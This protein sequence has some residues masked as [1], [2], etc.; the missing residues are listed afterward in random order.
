[1]ELDVV[2]DAPVAL[3][4]QSVLADEEVLVAGE[5]QHG[6][7]RRHAADARVGVDPHDRGVEGDARL[8]VPARIEGRIERQTVMR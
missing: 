1:M 6:V 5:A 8:R 2:E 4:R 3:D 7:A